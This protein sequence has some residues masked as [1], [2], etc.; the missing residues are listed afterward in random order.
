MKQLAVGNTS[1]SSVVRESDSSEAANI[2]RRFFMLCP[3]CL[4]IPFCFEGVMFGVTGVV[5]AITF[6][7]LGSSQ[8]GV[9]GVLGSCC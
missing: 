1:S 9:L 7:V 6:G 3:C 4:R 8:M 2:T 5:V